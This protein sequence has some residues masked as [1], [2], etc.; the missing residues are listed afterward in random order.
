M[1]RHAE[2]RAWWADVEDV[3]QRIEHRRATE[4]MA[5]LA[6]RRANV[7][8]D[9]QFRPRRTVSITGR[10]QAVAAPRLRLVEQA[11]APAA[12]SSNA[13]ARRRPR[14]RPIDRVGG[15]PDRI[16][17]WAVVL[18]FLLVLVAVLSAHS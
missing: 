18:G 8:E 5:A 3:K 15:R 6:R 10:P 16:A 9:S 1:P 17:A 14:P 2:A 11:P 7:P 13:R 12:S 4:R